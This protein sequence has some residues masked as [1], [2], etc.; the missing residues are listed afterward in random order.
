LL[1]HD[2]PAPLGLRRLELEHEVGER[3]PA[4]RARSG[5]AR[6]SLWR[7]PAPGGGVVGAA[8]T[9]VGMRILTIS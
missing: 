2:R 5:K 6:S 9:A 7:S 1:D 3:V 4:G 8:A